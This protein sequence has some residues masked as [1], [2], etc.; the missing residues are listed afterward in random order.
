MCWLF[1]I[2]SHTFFVTLFVCELL[3]LVI[4]TKGFRQAA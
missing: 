3:M 4:V 1:P 2:E